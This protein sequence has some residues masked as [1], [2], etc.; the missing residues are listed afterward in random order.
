MELFVIYVYSLGN[1]VT[2]LHVG[3]RVVGEKI[4]Y[5]NKPLSIKFLHSKKIR[6]PNRFR[7]LN[8]ELVQTAI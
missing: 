7:S 6:K 5:Y 3:I 2:L 4:K 1:Q 8:L